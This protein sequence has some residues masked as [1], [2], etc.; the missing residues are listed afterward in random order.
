MLRIV[1]AWSTHDGG[2]VRSHRPAGRKTYRGVRTHEASAGLP[3]NFWSMRY[4]QR[5]VKGVRRSKR[6]VD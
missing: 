3:L 1:C 4:S 6:T 2:T 5:S